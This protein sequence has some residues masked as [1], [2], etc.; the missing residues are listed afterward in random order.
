V[1][2]I[3]ENRPLSLVRLASAVTY[4]DGF[5]SIEG[6]LWPTTALAMIETLW[7]QERLGYVGDIAEIGVWKGK[8][9][10]ALAAG[11]RPQERLVAVD[12]FDDLASYGSGYKA[13]F[14]ANLA[15]FFPG[16]QP[17]IIEASSETL[18]N[19]P[20]A[21]GRLRCLSIDGGHSRAQTLNDLKLAD[22]CLTEQ[23]TCW[24]DDVFNQDWPGVVSG[25]FAYLDD[26]PGLHPVVMF[27]NKLV[28]VRPNMAET[29]RAQ[30]RALFAQTIRLSGIELNR[31]FID[32]YN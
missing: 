23:G 16:I 4:L 22:A 20:S 19:D 11:A 9:F 10:M 2:K 26:S 7:T 29:W 25:L 15:R 1:D 6:W 5:D 32:A 31:F 14:L 8:S 28:L 27:P 18:A 17:E 12:P 21:L 3:T 13:T 24:V 30:F